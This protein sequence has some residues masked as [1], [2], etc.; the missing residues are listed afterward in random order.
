MESSVHKRDLLTKFSKSLATS[1]DTVHI[2]SYFNFFVDFDF[3]PKSWLKA[4]GEEV[5]EI[6]SLYQ[7]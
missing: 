6:K 4:A 5:F 3:V 1:H 7:H 2:E